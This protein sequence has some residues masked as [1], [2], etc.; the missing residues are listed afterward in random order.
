[1]LHQCI[2]YRSYLLLTAFV[3]CMSYLFMHTAFIYC[4]PYLFIAYCIYVCIIQMKN[5]SLIYKK[6]LK[7]PKGQ[8]KFV[9]RR[10]TDNTMAKR[11]KEHKDKQRSTKYYT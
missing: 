1:M 2:A 5:V 11:K 4:I 8:S 3:Y 10:S 7:I 9:N 6:S